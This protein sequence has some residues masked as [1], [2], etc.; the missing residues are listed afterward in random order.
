[1]KRV[2]IADDDVFIVESTRQMLAPYYIVDT[3]TTG[4]EASM[5]FMENH[6]D[7]FITDV[8]FKYGINGLELL[9]RLRPHAQGCKFI[10]VSGIH[11]S[12]AVRQQAVDMGAV[13]TER[14]LTLELIQR[15]MEA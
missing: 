15:V 3:A 1:M 6:Y 7:G 4:S 10:V 9:S 14:P 8:D 2:L 11:Y 12:D 13:F 5:L